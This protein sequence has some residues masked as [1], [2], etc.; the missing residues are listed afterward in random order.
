MKFFDVVMQALTSGL[1]EAGS[2]RAFCERTKLRQST[3]S[4]WLS[5][6]RI[7]GLDI[8]GDA[9]DNYGYVFSYTIGDE[10]RGSVGEI[11]RLRAENQRLAGMV[12]ALNDRLDRVEQ[13]Y[14][15]GREPVKK[16][17]AG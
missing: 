5:G 16:D 11:Q 8:I 15:S 2:Q 3:L 13:R 12:D 7:P 4:K 17:R 9:L 1:K 6:E 14:W 10:E